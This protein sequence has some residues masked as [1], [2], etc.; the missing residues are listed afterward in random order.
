LVSSRLYGFGQ[1]QWGYKNQGTGGKAIR[2]KVI[3]E[4]VEEKT[5]LKTEK[6]IRAY[7]DKS[8]VTSMA[9]GAREATLGQGGGQRGVN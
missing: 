2:K 9:Q 3:L 6:K 4:K 1:I 8:G 7:R 5:R